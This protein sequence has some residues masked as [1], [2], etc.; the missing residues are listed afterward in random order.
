MSQT[1]EYSPDGGEVVRGSVKPGTWTQTWRDDNGIPTRTEIMSWAPE[2]SPSSSSATSTSNSASSSTDIS[3]DLRT[4][5]LLDTPEN[6]N[7]A[8]ETSASSGFSRSAV[9]GASVGA[10]T[11][12]IILFFLAY[13]LYRRCRRR[14]QTKELLSD[15]E[16][17]PGLQRTTSRGLYSTLEYFGGS[18]RRK[19]TAELEAI[20]R[21]ELEDTGKPAE[22][23]AKDEL[24]GST[25]VESSPQTSRTSEESGENANAKMS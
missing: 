21:Q 19:E 10:A 24:A 6:T 9:I 2:A 20:S 18:R 16:T 17:S 7:P 13:F 1:T 23:E 5:T 15:S 22:M 14:K 12:V 3:A 4:S 11:G 25:V 8:I